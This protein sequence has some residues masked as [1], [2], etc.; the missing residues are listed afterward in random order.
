[1]ETLAVIVAIA[2]I[3]VSIL[4]RNF[5]LP[6][7]LHDIFCW[8][9]RNDTCKPTNL[10]ISEVANDSLLL[11][12]TKPANGSERIKSYTILCHSQDDPPNQWQVKMSSTVEK[13]KVSGLDPKTTYIFKIRPESGSRFVVESDCSDPVETKPKVPGKPDRRPFAS[14][15]TDTSA[16]LRWH[17][18]VHGA[19][20]VKRYNI[21]YQVIDQEWKEMVSEGSGRAMLVD[22]LEPETRYTFKVFAVGDCG[23]GPESDSS[24]SVQTKMYLAQ[25]LKKKVKR[26][27]SGGLHPLFL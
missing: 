14:N 24:F 26:L 23:P 22:N 18:P 13:A 11:E 19:Y 12:W 21:L 27:S 25:Q 16:L 10:E 2:V 8:L 4:L 15:V 20:L 3:I 5:P 17:E 1:M 6:T 9:S 7:L